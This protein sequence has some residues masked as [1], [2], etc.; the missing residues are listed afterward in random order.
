MAHLLWGFESKPHRVEFYLSQN[1]KHHVP[2]PPPPPSPSSVIMMMVVIIMMK[3]YKIGSGC[4]GHCWLASAAP[5]F[6]PHTTLPPMHQQCTTFAPKMWRI[7][8]KNVLDLHHACDTFS[9]TTHYIC[10]K[11]VMY[12]PIRQYICTK[13]MIYFQQK[14]ANTTNYYST[15][16]LY[17]YVLQ[18][19]LHFPI[20]CCLCQSWVC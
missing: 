4:F 16:L 3:R 6:L 18:L 1:P 14:C 7:C 12:A 20:V 11:T 10:T 15:I 5:L 8:A 9:P 19:R 13:M 17:L 2:Y